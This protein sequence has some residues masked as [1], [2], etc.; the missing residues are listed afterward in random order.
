MNFDGP[1]LGTSLG[2]YNEM[3]RWAK[4]NVACFNVG[5][6]SPVVWKKDEEIIIGNLSKN[7]VKPRSSGGGY[8]I[9]KNIKKNVTHKMSYIKNVIFSRLR[10]KI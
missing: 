3:K 8:K 7:I 1:Q 6:S 10:N 9:K 4:K 2:D 5:N